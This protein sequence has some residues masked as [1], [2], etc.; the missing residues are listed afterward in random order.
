MMQEEEVEKGKK[1]DDGEIPLAPR[2]EVEI[3]ILLLGV[4]TRLEIN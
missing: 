2:I 4:G 1:E 3:R